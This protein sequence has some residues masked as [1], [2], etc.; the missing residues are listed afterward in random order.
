MKLN[1]EDFIKQLIDES[2]KYNTDLTNQQAEKLYEY[3]EFLLE[4]NSKINLTS[5]IEDT[6]I[7]A[8][9]FIDSL[10]CVKYI[11]EES[12]IIDVGTGAGFPGIVLAIYFE[13]KKEITLLDSLNKRVQFLNEV[14]SKLKLSNVIAIHARAEEFAHK[15]E[16]REK[17]DLAVARA[18]APLNILLEYLS[19]YVKKKGFCLCMK[20]LSVQEE[21]VASKKAIQELKL[22]LI[23]NDDISI[24]LENDKL[25]RNILVFK[26]LEGLADRYPR[27]YSNIKKKGL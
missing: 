10:M 9:H 23:T 20:A 5:I 16:Y 19:G 24:V 1:K 3:K 14:I 7:I 21:L 12:K 26:K 17:Y 25:C 2:K 15:E 13:G 4:W 27:S 8:K 18:V 11:K 6:E 22:R